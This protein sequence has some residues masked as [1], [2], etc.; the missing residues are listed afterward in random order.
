MLNRIKSIFSSKLRIAVF[1]V[2]S[3]GVIA[4]SSFFWSSMGCQADS[5]DS[6]ADAVSEDT[7]VVEDMVAAD[8]AEVAAGDGQEATNDT[9]STF[10]DMT[11]E[12]VSKDTAADTAAD[13]PEN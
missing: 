7:T 1:L 10:P 5:M 4:A 11:S 6:A 13:T 9:D 12:D 3:V 2:A 8:T